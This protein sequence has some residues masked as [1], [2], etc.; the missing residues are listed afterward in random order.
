LIQGEKT[1]FADFY[2]PYDLKEAQTFVFAQ[3]LKYDKER[4]TGDYLL[5]T[6][7]YRGNKMMVENKFD[8]ELG[9]G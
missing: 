6:K 1:Y 4:Y 3:Q 7:I 8:V 5:R 2:G 9:K